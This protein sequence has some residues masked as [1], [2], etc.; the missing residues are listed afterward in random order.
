[1]FFVKYML[2]SDNITFKP[3]IK[4]IYIAVGASTP[5]YLLRNSGSFINLLFMLR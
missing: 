2:Y 4:C 3:I 5:T 1:M